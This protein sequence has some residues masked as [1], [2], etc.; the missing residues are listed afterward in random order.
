MAL[1]VTLT[2]GLQMHLLRPSQTNQLFK[3]GEMRGT[4]ECQGV[5]ALDGSSNTQPQAPEGGNGLWASQEGA[6]L[7]SPKREEHGGVRRQLQGPKVRGQARLAHADSLA[8]AP[9]ETRTPALL[10]AALP[11]G[12]LNASPTC[13]NSCN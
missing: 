4:S 5:P 6:G 1:R 12:T 7:R 8:P 11:G 9:W 13:F 3:L 2:L 10:Q